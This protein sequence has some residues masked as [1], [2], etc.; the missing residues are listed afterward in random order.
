MESKRIFLLFVLVL[1]YVY[2]ITIPIS[3][4]FYDRLNERCRIKPTAVRNKFQDDT[5][6]DLSPESKRNFLSFISI[7]Y[8]VY[9]IAIPT[10]NQFYDR[11]NE[12]CRIKPMIASGIFQDNSLLDLSPGYRILPSGRLRVDKKTGIVRYVDF[13]S[14][15]MF[16]LMK[17]VI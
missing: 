13:Y 14:G 4:Q 7:L 11:L 10:S 5:L 12:R 9:K 16:N 1:F 3:N 17:T 6:L 15:E 2:K 8:H